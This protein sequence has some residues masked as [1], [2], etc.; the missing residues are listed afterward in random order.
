L[1][2]I[3]DNEV[4]PVLAECEAEIKAPIQIVWQV[5]TDLEKWPEWN[6]SV[7]EMHLQGEVA[8]GTEFRWKTGG[9]RIRSR[10]EEITSPVSIVWS[11][12]TMGIRAIHVWALTGTNESTSVW[13]GECFYGIVASLLASPLRKSLAKALQQGM[14]ALKKDAEKRVRAGLSRS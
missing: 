13:T 10:I 11:G 8:I 4:A 12:R 14:A 7:Q 1:D 9:M 2:Q 5:L 3:K 6:E